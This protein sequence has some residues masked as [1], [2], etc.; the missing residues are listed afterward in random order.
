MLNYWQNGKIYNVNS[1]PRYASGFPLNESDVY[2]VLSLNGK[3]RF[4]FCKSVNEVPAEFG[5]ADFDV[6]DFDYIDVP[7][8]WQIKGYDTPIYSNVKYPYAI[9]AIMLPM[10]PHIHPDKNP[11][12]LYSREFVVD[13]GGENVF[14]HFGGINSAAEIYV[15][16]NFVGYSEDTFDFQEYDITKYVRYG[17]NRL[18][19][20]VFRYTTGSYLE[21]QDMWRLSG[22]FRDVTLIYKP[23]VEISDMYFKSELSDNFD[24]AYLKG[25]VSISAKGQGLR[26]AKLIV[27]LSEYGNP[28]AVIYQQEINLGEITDGKTIIENID[29][30][31]DEV[32]RTSQS[33]SN[34]S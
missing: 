26:H 29:Q 11:V 23:K 21:D 6:S 16:G 14:L 8:E 2:T 34:Q 10:V 27:T 5:R 31:I 18:D 33:V 7:S 17:E 4:K 20:I 12:G 13:E 30:K 32:A 3:W 1:I 22:I 28:A 9:E 25:N 19:V 24:F 15:N